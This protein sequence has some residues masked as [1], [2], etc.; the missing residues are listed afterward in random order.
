MPRT[1]KYYAPYAHRQIMQIFP[2][3]TMNINLR[4]SIENTKPEILKSPSIGN[5][6]NVILQV[7]NLL[8]SLRA[9]AK[10][11]TISMRKP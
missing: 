10:I 9:I 4:P 2:Y 11:L 5:V 7:F 1:T 3:S 8:R 6:V